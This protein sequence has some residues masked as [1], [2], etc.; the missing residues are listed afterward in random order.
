[1]STPMYEE[2]KNPPIF[3]GTGILEKAC[4][5]EKKILGQ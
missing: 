4:F 2:R 1:M 5:R 3:P